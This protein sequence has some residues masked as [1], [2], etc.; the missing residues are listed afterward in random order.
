[1]ATKY[2]RSRTDEKKERFD[3]TFS[4]PC[5]RLLHFSEQH[6]ENM[7]ALTESALMSHFK[8]K[9]PEEFHNVIEKL[10][11]Q[12][13]LKLKMEKEQ[14]DLVIKQFWENLIFIYSQEDRGF[15]DPTPHYNHALRIGLHYDDI[16]DFTKERDKKIK[17]NDQNIVR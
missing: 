4:A 8:I 5:A 12:A 9:H 17:E 6:G 3:L 2:Y 11:K 13:E 10:E 14:K 7:S 16:T 1:M 15:I